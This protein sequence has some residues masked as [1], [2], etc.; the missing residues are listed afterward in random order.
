L[1]QPITFSNPAL[2]SSG[3]VADWWRNREFTDSHGTLSCDWP[4]SCSLVDGRHIASNI[5]KDGICW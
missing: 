3:H 4:Q 5:S 1:S 2:N